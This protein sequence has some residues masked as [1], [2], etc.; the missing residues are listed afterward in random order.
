MLAK[1]FLSWV[2]WQGQ[3]A[4]ALLLYISME[5]ADLS[6]FSFCSLKVYMVMFVVWAC[7]ALYKDWDDRAQS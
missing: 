3:V 7:H 4:I 1:T 6:L 5:K 2:N